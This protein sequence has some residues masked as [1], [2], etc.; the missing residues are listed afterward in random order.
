MGTGE[1][2]GLGV[3]DYK[4]QT[5][6][7]RMNKQQGPTIEHRELYSIFCNKPKWKRIRKKMCV[8]MYT[9]THV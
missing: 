1:W 6:I 4:M 9:H 3:W 5:S 8:C 7:H 2:D